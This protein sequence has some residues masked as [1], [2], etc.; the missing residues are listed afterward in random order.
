MEREIKI[1]ALD[2]LNSERSGSVKAI[3][4]LRVDDLIIRNVKILEGR[5]GKLRVVIP[6]VK[7]R[8]PDGRVEFRPLVV[9]PRELKAKADDLIFEEYQKRKGR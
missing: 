7:L 5:D 4:D 2:V 1:L 6:S 3:S 8:S 9:L